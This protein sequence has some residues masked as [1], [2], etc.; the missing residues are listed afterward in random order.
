M[1]HGECDLECSPK[2]C[3]LLAFL[4]HAFEYRDPDFG[5]QGEAFHV[6]RFPNDDYSFQSQKNKI[7]LCNRAF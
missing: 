4:I 3:I 7:S 6:K 2:T 5:F 1:P